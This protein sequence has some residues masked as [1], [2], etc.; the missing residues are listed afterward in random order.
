MTP[1]FLKPSSIEWFSRQNLINLS[2]KSDTNPR[3]MVLFRLLTRT[4]DLAW[5]PA[6]KVFA[7]SS[8]FTV[9]LDRLGSSR[10]IAS[11]KVNNIFLVKT[12]FNGAFPGVGFHVGW[13]SAKIQDLTRHQT[14]RGLPPLSAIQSG[15]NFIR[16]RKQAK[17]YTKRGSSLPNFSM[18]DECTSN[19]QIW[20]VATS[21]SYTRN[22][23]ARNTTAGDGQK[24]WG[25]HI[26]S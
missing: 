25:E 2:D 8:I 18:I 17:H 9:P 13:L 3:R 22:A 4:I 14:P 6:L 20:M 7:M 15:K 23:S 26:I 12:R 5:R 19:Y 21:S 1:L 16:H 24:N 11:K 10:I